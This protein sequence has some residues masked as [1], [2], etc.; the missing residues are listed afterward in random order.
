MLFRSNLK[1]RQAI[2]D[3]MLKASKGI[4]IP[5]DIGKFD[6]SLKRGSATPNFSPKRPAKLIA[7]APDRPNRNNSGGMESR[8]MMTEA[9]KARFTPLDLEPDEKTKLQPG[10]TLIFANEYDEI[11]R[12]EL[13]GPQV[14]KVRGVPGVR[15][16][17]DPEPDNKDEVAE[18]MRRWDEDFGPIDSAQR[19]LRGQSQPD[20]AA[21]IGRA[22]V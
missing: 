11:L 5:K 7:S 12:T 6:E 10:T 8:R 17:I 14:A 19:Q 18:I 3:E 9:E 2:Y 16:F 13:I 20:R 22:H 1:K 4:S 15:L 21:Q